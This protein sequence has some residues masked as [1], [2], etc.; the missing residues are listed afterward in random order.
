MPFSVLMSVY[1]KESSVFLN[2]AFQSIFDQTLKAD[3]FIL[4]KDGPLPDSLN[5]CIERWIELLNIKL[6]V[7]DVN[8]GLGNALN[9][10][11]ENCSNDLVIR[12]DSDDLN[13]PTRFETQVNFMKNNPDVSASSSNVAEFNVT[14]GDCKR[15]RT[16][17]CSPK[18][19]KA[20]VVSRNPMNHMATIF[21]K[22]SVTNVGGYMHLQY[23]EDYYLWIRLLAGGYKIENI[24]ATLVF[25]RVGN[26]M[27]SRR[28]GWDYAKSEYHLYNKLRKYKLSKYIYS[29]LIF[30]TRFSLRIFPARLLGHL[31]FFLRKRNQVAVK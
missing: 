1:S 31:Y 13:L 4:V 11:L 2:S 9:A 3:E 14:P 20:D 8:V 24:D 22:S 28:R 30:I 15:I 17:P 19:I 18:R 16:I 7:L 25:A 12:C 29:E 23:M 10:G 5:E 26:G 6:V 21:R 27:L